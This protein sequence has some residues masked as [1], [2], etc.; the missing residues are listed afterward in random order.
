MPGN[1][2]GR[3]LDLL[4]VKL[5]AA[6]GKPLTPCANGCAEKNITPLTCDNLGGLSHDPDTKKAICDLKRVPITLGGEKSS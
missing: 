5:A 2:N 1:E 6:Q 3:H 4:E